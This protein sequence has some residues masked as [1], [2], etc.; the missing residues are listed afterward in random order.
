MVSTLF[1]GISQA[2][3]AQVQAQ[4]QQQADLFKSQEAQYQASIAKQN[5]T[6]ADQNAS[7]AVHAGEVEAQQ[8]AIKVSEDLSTTRAQQGAGNLDINSGSNAEV[9]S[10][11]MSVGQENISM[12]RSNAQKT[13][14]G[15]E[16]QA[17]QFGEQANWDMTTSSY[18]QQAASYAKTAGDISVESSILGTVGKLAGQGASAYK[19]GTFT[20]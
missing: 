5:Q 6:I 13:A 15:Y 12:I 18:E 17:Y 8:E 10:A 4:A 19:S 14:Y 16:V 1:G 20:S 11:M 3:G 7:Y 9:R 2:Q